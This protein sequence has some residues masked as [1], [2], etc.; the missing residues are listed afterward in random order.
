[1][2]VRDFVAMFGLARPKQRVVA[3]WEKTGWQALER[4]EVQPDKMVAA[5]NDLFAE[6]RADAKR[7]EAVIDR[8]AG[9]T[10]RGIAVW[11]VR[12]PTSSALGHLE[13]RRGGL[14]WEDF[15]RRAELAGARWLVLPTDGD[16]R[17]TIDGSHLSRGAALR[18][19][20]LVADTLTDSLAAD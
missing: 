18:F 13:D 19:S 20:E 1:M 10:E 17:T 14:D 12:M 9:W 4:E 3:S 7:V 5:Y 16:H 15:R 8:I 6:G 2:G 11:I